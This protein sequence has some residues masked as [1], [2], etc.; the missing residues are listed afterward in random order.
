LEQNRE[1]ASCEQGPLHRIERFP[2]YE[3]LLHAVH[4][5]VEMRQRAGTSRFSRL[6]EMGCQRFGASFQLSGKRPSAD[7]AIYHIGHSLETVAV[8]DQK[9]GRS[10]HIVLY[11]T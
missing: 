11:A 10:F 4:Q 5:A 9:S 8:L 1:R 3:H 7:V 6:S 2:C